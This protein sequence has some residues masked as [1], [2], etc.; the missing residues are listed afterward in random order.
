MNR[1]FPVGGFAGGI[2]LGFMVG[3]VFAIAQRAWRD[4]TTVRKS[5]PGLQK[6]AWRRT[7]RSVRWTAVVLALLFVAIGWATGG[8]H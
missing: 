4:L 1:G 6:A 8:G 5:I 3:Y 2:V 7:W